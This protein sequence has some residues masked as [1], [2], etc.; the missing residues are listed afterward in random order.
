VAQLVLPAETVLACGPFFTNVLLHEGDDG[1]LLAPLADFQHELELLDMAAPRWQRRGASDR[2]VSS[3][4]VAADELDL[5]EALVV[6]GVAP[7]ERS[8]VLAWYLRARAGIEAVRAARRD[9]EQIDAMGAARRRWGNATPVSIPPVPLIADAPSALP[10]EFRAYLEG[11]V[12]YWSGDL[13]AARAAWARVLS[14]PMPLRRYRSTWASYMLGRSL[15]RENPGAAAEHMRDVREL[16]D[17]G[18]FDSVGLAAESLGWEARA[19]L[20]AGSCSEAVRLYL[21]QYAAGDLSAVVSLRRAVFRLLQADNSAL[22][23]AAADDRVRSVVTALLISRPTRADYLKGGGPC[24]SC[25]DAKRLWLD[26]VESAGIASVTGADRLAWLAYQAGEFDQAARWLAIADPAEPLGVWLHAKLLLHKGHLLEGATLLRELAAA[27]PY[28]SETQDPAS[29]PAPGFGKARMRPVYEN[30]PFAQLHDGWESNPAWGR[31]REPVFTLGGELGVM[32]LALGNFTAALRNLEA[33]RFGNDAQYL[34]E[35]VLTTEE[36]EQFIASGAGGATAIRR[37]GEWP[38]LRQG[39]AAADYETV[40]DDNSECGTTESAVGI[41]CHVLAA[42][43]ARAGEWKRAIP[44]FQFFQ[45]RWLAV[46][47]VGAAQTGADSGRSRVE[48]GSA[49]FEAARIMRDHGAHL[50]GTMAHPDFHMFGGDYEFGSWLDSRSRR[51]L[52]VVAPTTEE[53]RRA[54]ASM[55]FPHA[56]K[57]WHYRYVAADLA[58]RAASYFT[59]GSDEQAQVLCTA[60]SWLAPRDPEAADR[61]Y[62]ALVRRCGETELGRE[63]DRK[64]WFPDCRGPLTWEPI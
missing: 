48:R 23:R 36:L 52:R 24:E 2:D 53:L 55:R 27:H 34:G 20:D 9:Q 13:P 17:A 26:A 22:V 16:A 3:Q 37:H 51:G 45:T 19:R 4:V 64:R 57:R 7:H 42:R 29:T 14:L 11:A 1:V 6:A 38:Q 5:T 62:K 61:F 33:A 49:L 25:A 40:P 21:D 50:I 58:W 59:A 12:A 18:F 30:Y 47:Y 8:V 63:A 56:D 28:R 10:P 60:G 54:A 46:R 44:W 39:I 32:E 41:W 43:L 15:L 31:S 35:Q